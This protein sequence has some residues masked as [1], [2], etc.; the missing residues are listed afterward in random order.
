MRAKT[1]ALWGRVTGQSSA[2][3][4]SKS[5][6]APG[7]PPPSLLVPPPPVPPV[8]RP[9]TSPLPDVFSAPP[10][11]PLSK[12]LPPIRTSL[13]EAQDDDVRFDDR[14]LVLVERERDRELDGTVRMPRAEA[15]GHVKRRSQSL[16]ELELPAPPRPGTADRQP[17]DH[18]ERQ[19][20]TVLDSAT[21]GFLSDFALGPSTP[22]DLRVPQTPPRA[23]PTPLSSAALSLSSAAHSH[24]HSPA[25]YS[26]S[27]SASAASTSASAASSPR[28]PPIITVPSTPSSP[29]SSPA[30]II[31][32]RSSSLGTPPTTGRWAG[33]RAAS[34]TIRAPTTWGRAG[35]A[36]TTAARLWGAGQAGA[37]A[38]F[39]SEPSLVAG[40]ED[41][42]QPLSAVSQQDLRS[43]FEDP[44]AREAAG[45]CWEEDEEFVQKEKIAEWLGGVRPL[46]KA[47]L[48]HYMDRFDFGGL[49][50]DMAF[51]RFCAKLYLKA[52]TQQ[53]DRIL[54]EFS[55]RYWECNPGSLFGSA[56]VVH[57]VSYSLLL[58]NTDLHV[59]EL[60]SRMSKGQ[61]VRNTLAT[62]RMQLRPERDRS[63]SDLTY[64]DDDA[65][66][67]ATD[68]V[69]PR[70]KRSDS[71]TS[72]N[73]ITRDMLTG[74][75]SSGQ[76]AK[77]NDS[78]VS[79]AATS[80]A[81]SKT[82]S[83]LVAPI[84]YDRNWESD[85]ESLLKDM[86]NAIKNQQVLQ[87]VPDARPSTGSGP[88]GTV[89]RNRSLR[90][91]QPDRL[92]TLKRG[93]IRGIQSILGA[94][95]GS[96][97]GGA[98]P[99]DGRASP[100]PSFATSANEALLGS[101]LSFMTPALGFAS[102]LSHTIIREQQEDDERS[103]ESAGTADTTISITD[104]E[105]ALLGPPWAKEGMLCR[106]QYNESAG[107]R[108]RSKAWLD[109]FVVIQKGELS[110]FVFGGQ[111]DGPGA[112]A[113][114]VGGGNWLEN[115]RPVGTLLLAHALAHALPPPGYNR[116]RPHCM[117]LTLASGAVYFFQAGTE[118]LVNEWVQTCNYWAA[119]QSK[120]P[121]AGGVSNMEYG[122]NRVA[123][124][125]HAD[126]ESVRGVSVSASVPSQDFDA[127]SV[128]SGR[129][130]FAQTVRGGA[131]PWQDRTFVNEWKAPQPPA[132]ASVHD[133]EAQLE[134][135]RR[136]VSAMTQEL[137]EHNDLR[138]P[139]VAL[140]AP[141]SANGAK[142]LANWEKK[143]KWLLSEIVKYESY[144]DSLQ[145]AMA[146][147]LKKRGEKALERA[148]R[149][150]REEEEE[151]ATPVVERR[152]EEKEKERGDD[153]ESEEGDVFVEAEEGP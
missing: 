11:S 57:A 140:Y 88:P 85:M 73:S 87:N 48:R 152:G 91:Q 131:S 33:Q 139:M 29:P 74:A 45:K 80:N 78:A 99:L 146:L 82:P 120:E 22:L 113:V 117:V 36:Q 147:R 150:V 109:V 127:V 25:P 115:A 124:P 60:S 39:S 81:E 89:G 38:A 4:R 58:L 72:W 149:D 56:S 31:P 136:H 63:T 145:A 128:R 21:F 64:E 132:V 110:M 106:K 84:V 16:G 122:W 79:V 121:L 116:Q 108:A 27:T 137:Q 47:A 50:L 14:S 66:L 93:S 62:I 17:A 32:P 46:N 37:R 142:A 134:A 20:S 114:V 112:H 9:P 52:E 40:P 148:L 138:T 86:Y 77:S 107:K 92:T 105:L 123:D 144:I 118:E 12:P 97:Y 133:E 10:P 41:R 6:A 67:G 3:D 2:R 34:A 94:Q 102:N 96:P 130:K 68:T 23:P 30:P 43:R 19:A 55:R 51:R 15:L 76:L 65:G 141:R 8:P 135:L 42:A 54:E 98:S 35:P 95:G 126:D 69:K 111:A 24:S 75:G 44:E 59:A 151:H 49:R 7:P 83:T 1:S 71:I 13:D 26:A 28:P 61:F 5:D 103:G 18:H 70:A 53:V 104:E 101:T 125:L 100:A 143:S 119:R 129:S 90:V 153:V